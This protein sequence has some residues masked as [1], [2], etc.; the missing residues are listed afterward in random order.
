[1]G[2]ASQKSDVFSFGIMLLE[3]FTG[4]RPTDLM[5]VEGFSLRQWVSQAF[6]ARLIDV[7]DRKLL[8]DEEIRHICFDHQTNTSLGSSSFISTS[9]SILASVFEL[10]LMCSSE[11]VGQ[12]MSMNEVATRLEDIEKD[13]YY[14]ALVQAMQRHY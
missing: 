3:V 2:K 5:F 4:K 6:P 1:M 8:Q 7:V 9:N 10:G 13:H 12:R 14:S 11:S